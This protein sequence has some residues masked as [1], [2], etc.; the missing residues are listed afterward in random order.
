MKFTKKQP[1]MCIFLKLLL[2]SQDQRAPNYSQCTS[3]LNDVFCVYSVSIIVYVLNGTFD[4]FSK[5]T[6]KSII[7]NILSIKHQHNRKKTQNYQIEKSKIN[8]PKL[9]NRVHLKNRSLSHALFRQ[10]QTSWLNMF[11]QFAWVVE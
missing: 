6:L 5:A 9:S 11:R 4:L 10:L 2:S 3:F 1:S 7:V 8:V